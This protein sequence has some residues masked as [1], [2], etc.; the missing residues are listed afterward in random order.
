MTTLTSRTGD[1]GFHS[2]RQGGPAFIHKSRGVTGVY[3]GDGGFI[4]SAWRSSS[5]ACLEGGGG[6]VVLYLR[7]IFS[8]GGRENSFFFFA[9]D[10]F[11]SSR[12]YGE[13]ELDLG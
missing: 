3:T 8:R 12:S 13:L 5:F 1:G 4:H 7:E 6:D 9:L 2:R 10:L 11:R